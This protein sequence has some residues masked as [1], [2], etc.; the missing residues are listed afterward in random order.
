MCRS[1]TLPPGGCEAKAL[2][3]PR[4]G[5]GARAVRNDGAG[6]LTR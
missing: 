2:D 4:I 1:E 5:R 6:A 3:S